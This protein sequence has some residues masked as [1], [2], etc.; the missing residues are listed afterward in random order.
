MYVPIPAIAGVKD[1]LGAG[2]PFPEPTY[3]VVCSYGLWFTAAVSFTSMVV[4][5]GARPHSE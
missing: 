1:V 3:G 5:K 2:G 4:T